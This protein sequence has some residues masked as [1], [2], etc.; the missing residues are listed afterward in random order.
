MTDS[1]TTAF[2]MDAFSA[3]LA[4]K[5]GTITVVRRLVRALYATLVALRDGESVRLTR[6]G[7]ELV[8]STE[9]PAPPPTRIELTGPT[10]EGGVVVS[11]PEE[12]RLEIVGLPMPARIR[13]MADT[14]ARGGV[15][16]RQ[17]RI[18]S[19]VVDR[20]AVVVSKPATVH[21]ITAVGDGSVLTADGVIT[22][23]PA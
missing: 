13:I 1:K 4:V 9:T 15:P 10:P 23:L 14:G 21:A 5:P 22:Y 18:E 7:D 3:G 6:H 16:P 20:L 12:S 17:V 8:L 2:T 19:R 11:V